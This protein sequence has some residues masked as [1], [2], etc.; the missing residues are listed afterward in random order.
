[1]SCFES[2][3][4]FRYSRDITVNYVLGGVSS[5]AERHSH[6][7]VRAA[8]ERFPSLS[9]EE[10]GALYHS[11]FVFPKFPTILG[12]PESR[13]E[14]IW[15]FLDR[16]SADPHLLRAVASALLEEVNRS[17]NRDAEPSTRNGVNVRTLLKEH[18]KQLLRR[19]PSAYRTAQ[20]FH[21]RIRGPR[22]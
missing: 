7:C 1:M 6:E 14:F 13:A 12:R 20:R 22:V 15:S 2:S 4:R 21:A 19:Y 5:D 18:A 17:R 11:F 8:R 16:H 10:A 3:V 9:L